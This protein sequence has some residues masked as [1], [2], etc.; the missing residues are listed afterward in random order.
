M[1]CYFDG[2]GAVCLLFQGRGREEPGVGGGPGACVPRPTLSLFLSSPPSLRVLCVVCA[3]TRTRA[4][5]LS[6]VCVK[7]NQG[8][9]K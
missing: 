3:R 9:E 1:S 2:G 4:R 7:G 6:P 8:H 5:S